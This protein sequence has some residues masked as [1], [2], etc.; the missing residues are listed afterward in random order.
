MKSFKL[1]WM[2]DGGMGERLIG[3]ILSGQ[4]TATS[5]PVSDPDDPVFD[6]GDQLHLIDKHNKSRGILVVTRIEL[7]SFGQFD[8]NIAGALGLPLQE[9]RHAAHFANGREIPA[10]EAMRVVYFEVIPESRP[11]A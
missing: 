9:L 7:R 2:G 8:D 1:G 11:Q 3:A 10:E 5:C 4:K 6:V